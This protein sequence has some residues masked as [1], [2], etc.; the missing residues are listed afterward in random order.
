MANITGFNLGKNRKKYIDFVKQDANSILQK[1]PKYTK[2]VSKF[3]T[4]VGAVAEKIIHGA[5]IDVVR[6]EGIKPKWKDYI[7]EKTTGKKFKSRQDANNFMKKLSKE[8]KK[9]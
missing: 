1:L 7:K 4:D 9:L 2:K 6:S 3:L 5:N 8:Y